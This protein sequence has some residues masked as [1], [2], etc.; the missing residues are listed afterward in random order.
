MLIEAHGQ[1]MAGLEAIPP[2]RRWIVATE[3]MAKLLRAQAKL[4]EANEIERGVMS[5]VTGRQG[6]KTYGAFIDDILKNQKEEDERLVALRKRI[7]REE[8]YETV[9]TTTAKTWKL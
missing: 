8:T 7:K 2:A 1:A 3:N 9:E 6:P 5:R 4:A